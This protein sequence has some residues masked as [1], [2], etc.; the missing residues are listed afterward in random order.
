MLEDF[1]KPNVQTVII[2][3]SLSVGIFS[4][5]ITVA[6][7]IL[8]FPAQLF[9]NAEKEE[10]ALHFTLQAEYATKTWEDKLDVEVSENIKKMLKLSTQF[11]NNSIPGMEAPGLVIEDVMKLERRAME[12][13]V[14]YITHYLTMC[15]DEKKVR[16]DLKAGKRKK[17]S[18]DDEE[19]DLDEEPEPVKEPAPLPPP[20][21]QPTAPALPPPRLPSAQLP[22]IAEP[23]P[24]ANRV[25]SRTPSQLATVREPSAPVL[26]TG[27]SAS[28][29]VPKPEA[30]SEPET[31][32]AAGDDGN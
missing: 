14:A 21:R 8:D 3:C 12:K 18:D 22:P 29:V 15:E 23:T 27:G 24:A 7:I 5:V 16:S 30:A 6:N 17:K 1:S 11:E 20:P 31:T 19:E 13:R 9:D 28:A 25:P 4:L 10:E 2:G 32:A 26:T